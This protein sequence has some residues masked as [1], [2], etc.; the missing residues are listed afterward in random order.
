MKKDDNI[1]AWVIAVGGSA[2]GFALTF[3]VKFGITQEALFALIGALIGAAATIGGAA[4]LS[5]RNRNFERDAEV[6]LLVNEFDKLL[7]KAVAVQGVQPG[8]GMPLPKEYRPRLFSLAEAAGNVHAIAAEALSHGKALSFIHRAAV[9]RVQFAIDEYLR[10][11]TDA[12][13]EGDLDPL[14][15]RSFPEA[16]D[17]IADECKVAIAELNGAT[18][19]ADD[20]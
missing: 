2:T 9:R 20:V 14:D 6:T 8:S 10:F 13:A 1:P 16:T 17:K 11:W 3:M 12:N 15:E 19:F 4:W 7:K 5:D 18:S